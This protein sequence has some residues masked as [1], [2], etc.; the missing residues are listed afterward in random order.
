M[1]EI[2][3]ALKR[4][5]AS[6][7]EYH[8]FYLFAIFFDRFTTCLFCHIIFPKKILLNERKSEFRSI[9]QF[10]LFLNLM[11]LPRLECFYKTRWQKRCLLNFYKIWAAKIIFVRFDISPRVILWNNVQFGYAF[12]NI[13]WWAIFVQHMVRY[14]I[15]TKHI[16]IN[17]CWFIHLI[18]GTTRLV[19]WKKSIRIQ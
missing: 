12:I 9:L 14:A 11:I 16:A 4:Q 18:I 1:L 5:Q 2:Y 17:T 13:F 15:W 7:I 8:K 6:C 19:A 3:L 10:L